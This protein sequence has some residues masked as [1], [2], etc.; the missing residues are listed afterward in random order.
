MKNLKCKIT[1]DYQKVT[2]VIRSSKNDGH[3]LA[4]SKL[5]DNFARVNLNRISIDEVGISTHVKYFPDLRDRCDE[6][7]KEL[8]QQQIKINN[9][10]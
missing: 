4:S 1:E 3:L 2:Q 8:K 5:I 7:L 10:E 6:L 9:D